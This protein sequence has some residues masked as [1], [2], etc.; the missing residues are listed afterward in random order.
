MTIA[1]TRR[2]AQRWLIE[3]WMLPVTVLFGLA[4]GV[5]HILLEHQPRTSDAL[6]LAV[7]MATLVA[8]YLYTAETR[9]LRIASSRDTALQQHPWLEVSDLII[10]RSAEGGAVL[11]AFDLSSTVRN[12]GKTPALGVVA[13]LT[14]RR[15]QTTGPTFISQIGGIIVPRQDA[16]LS[17]RVP[18]DEPQRIVVELRVSYHTVFGRTA[19]TAAE[20]LVSPPAEADRMW[21]DYKWDTGPIKSDSVRDAGKVEGS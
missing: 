3:N 17:V 18:I 21:S 19:T 8:V 7:L 14:A 13:T 2:R 5:L 10:K 12:V 15:Y 6:Q 4:A 11:G 9:K 20:Y 16:G 1:E